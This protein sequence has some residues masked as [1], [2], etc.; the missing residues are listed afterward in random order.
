MAKFLRISSI[1]NDFV[2]RLVC[3]NQYNPNYFLLTISGLF[4]QYTTETI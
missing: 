2:D 3:N 1:S 4:W